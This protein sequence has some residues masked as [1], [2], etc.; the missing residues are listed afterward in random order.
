MIVY[1]SASRAGLKRTDKNILSLKEYIST[2]SSVSKFL[3]SNSVGS[4]LLLIFLL[5]L[6]I[7]MKM[8]KQRMDKVYW[9]V[10]NLISR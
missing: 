5:L 4:F 6:T 3:F 1:V 8:T 7:V 2:N 10:A 9:T